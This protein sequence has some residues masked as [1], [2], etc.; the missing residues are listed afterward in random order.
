MLW[1]ICV[2]C[3]VYRTLTRVHIPLNLHID[4]TVERFYFGK[5]I[6]SDVH[7]EDVSYRRTES[8]WILFLP[9][10]FSSKLIGPNNFST[11]L[12]YH[13][14]LGLSLT[15]PPYQ[16]PVHSYEPYAIWCVGWHICLYQAYVLRLIP[17]IT[18]Q[19]HGSV[20]F[21]WPPHVMRQ[22]LGHHSI[23]HTGL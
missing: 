3:A 21:S 16:F 11:R 8:R 1:L 14:Q 10:I 5:D 2:L 6:L 7:T 22:M 18:L 19:Q 15:F 17:V 13:G 12:L 23:A 20:M 4:S 9:I